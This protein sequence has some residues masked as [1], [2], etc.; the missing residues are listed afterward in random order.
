MNPN[1]INIAVQ[2]DISTAAV[3]EQIIEINQ[4]QND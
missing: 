2:N 4:I 3:S 1:N